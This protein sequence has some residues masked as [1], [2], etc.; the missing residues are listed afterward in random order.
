MLYAL[1][2][3]A[4]LEPIVTPTGDTADAACSLYRLAYHPAEG[5]T[6]PTTACY[7]ASCA[8]SRRLM[9]S[10]EVIGRKCL[11]SLIAP[12]ALAL[13]QL[14]GPDEAASLH[15][16][17]ILRGGLNFP[18]EEACH[19]AGHTVAATDFVSCERVIKDGV[20]TGLDIRY[21]N[22][23]PEPAVTL[24]IGDIIASGATL[25]ECLPLIAKR[26]E[27][28]GGSLRRIIFFTI[29]GTK[30]IPILDHFARQLREIWPDFEGITCVFYEGIFTV[31]EDH[32]VTGVNT[33]DIDFG[34]QGGA[35]APELRRHITERPTALFEKCTIYDGGA[36]RFEIR[37]H[38]HEVTEYWEALLAVAPEADAKAFLAEKLGYDAPIDYETWLTTVH[39]ED[40]AENRLLWA[41]EHNM[42]ARTLPTL[43]LPSLCKQRLQEFRTAM[44]F[45]A[46][47]PD[48]RNHQE[49]DHSIVSR[50]PH[51]HIN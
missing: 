49:P 48:N 39:L 14:L 22:L 36:R 3:T 33:P 10:P 24:L 38:I 41:D 4:Y 51:L 34:W 47:T 26:F 35:V 28:E 42:V 7:V 6:T 20:I 43:S 5:Q 11:E 15:I 21:A 37:N 8:M 13:G 32:G 29:G 9:T 46:E 40:C 17:N 19:N 12:T 44:A 27:Q 31:Y 25:H 1:P 45:I 2:P 18:I 23:V 16:L 50:L 30:A